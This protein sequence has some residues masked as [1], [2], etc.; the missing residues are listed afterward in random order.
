MIICDNKNITIKRKVKMNITTMIEKSDLS[1]EARKLAGSFDEC[2]SLQDFRYALE[3]GSFLASEGITS[4][5]LVEELY[6][7]CIDMEM[8]ASGF[9]AECG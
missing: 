4:Q 6:G 8:Q 7:Y 1:L 9:C 2:E 5:E 3:D